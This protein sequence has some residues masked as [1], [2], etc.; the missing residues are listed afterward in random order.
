MQLSAAALP[1]MVV[2]HLARVLGPAGWGAL[3]S[4]EAAGRCLSLL[5]EY[6]FQLSATRDV[7]QAGA[8]RMNRRR[9]VSGVGSAQLGLLAAGGIL[10][11]LAGRIWP[12]AAPLIALA[13]VWAAC[14]SLS[15]SWYL[16]GVE[17][18]GVMAWVEIPPRI[19]AALAILWFVRTPAD[20]WLALS[21]QALAAAA[22]ALAGWTFVARDAGLPQFSL[23][24]GWRVLAGGAPVFLFR[25]AVSL[26]TTANVLLL[27]LFAAPAIVAQFAGAEKI[28]RAAIS[29]TGPVSQAFYPRINRLMR[30][31]GRGAANELRASALSM[32]A[33]GAAIGAGVLLCAAPLVRI[34]LGPGYEGSASLLRLLAVVP[35]L[36][37]ASNVLGIQWMLPLRMDREFTGIVLAAGL[38]NLTMAALLG[39]RGQAAGMAVSLVAAETAVTLGCVLT[40]SSRG[41]APWRVAP[42]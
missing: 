11:L 6:G 42:V 32:L 21:F 40:L 13:L 23:D 30:T 4:A 25:G 8:S 26:Y 19:A 31:G 10:A 28:V 7:A 1:L 35:L 38:L 37:V 12:A 34:V 39:P 9:V 36:V 5:V 27:G 29:L 41:L 33:L 20:A 15:P 18:M 17:R 22:T 2:P 3:A 24:A 16:Q 14:Q